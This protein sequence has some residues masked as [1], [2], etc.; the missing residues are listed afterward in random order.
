MTPLRPSLPSRRDLLT[1]Y[2]GLLA[3]LPF[4]VSA[5]QAWMGKDPAYWTSQDVQTILQRSP[6]VREVPLE[7]KPATDHERSRRSRPVANATDYKITVRWES[8]LPI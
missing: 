1:I 7:L 5:D 8:A 3:L 2:P 4:G 6:W